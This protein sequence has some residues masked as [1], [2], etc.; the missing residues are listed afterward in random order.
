VRHPTRWIALGVA[1][2]VIVVGI[3]LATQV[4]GDPRADATRSQLVGDAAPRFSVRPLGGTTLSRADLAGRAV[5]VNFWN[6][7]CAPCHAELPALKQFWA[8]HRDD[9]S[10]AFVGI[11]RDDRESAVRDY[12]ETE[13]IDWT[14]A[15]DPAARAALDFGTRGQPETFAISPEGLIAGAQIGPSSLKDLETMLAAAQGGPR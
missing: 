4:G 15:M 6:T 9:P 3:V 10:V 8:R 13:G 11:V 2:V 1:V 12:V 7:W 14:I 5:I